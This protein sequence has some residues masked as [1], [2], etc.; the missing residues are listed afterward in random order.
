VRRTGTKPRIL[1]TEDAALVRLYYRQALTA[2]GFAVEE[3]LNGIEA[4]ERL[5][6]S[7]PF[8][9]LILDINMPKMDGLTCLRTLRSNPGPTAS[10]PVLMTSSEADAADVEAARMAGA[11]YYLVKPVAPE[12]LCRCTTVLTGWRS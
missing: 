7:E 11:N 10:V 6:V 5:A 9:L 1:V 4:L 12:E 8:D 3:A 2:T